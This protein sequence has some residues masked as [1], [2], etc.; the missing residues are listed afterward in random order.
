MIVQENAKA[1]PGALTDA[2]G[3]YYLLLAIHE[4]W[5]TKLDHLLDAL[6]DELYGEMARGEYWTR[7]EIKE[8]ARAE[9]ERAV[10]KAAP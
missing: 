9:V 6:E 1:P 3:V 4:E 7:Q 8:R 2:E 5:A 10:G